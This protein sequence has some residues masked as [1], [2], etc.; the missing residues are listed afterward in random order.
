[1]RPGAKENVSFCRQLFQTHCSGGRQ[2]AALLS[3]LQSP[4]ALGAGLLRLSSAR[5]VEKDADFERKQLWVWNHLLLQRPDFSQLKYLRRPC[6]YHSALWPLCLNCH[7]RSEDARRKTSRLKSQKWRPVPIRACH[8]SQMLP[9]STSFRQRPDASRSG[10]AR[11]LGKSGT[12]HE[13]LLFAPCF[14]NSS[15]I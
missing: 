15:S 10:S 9:A 13:C 4:S 14:R 3:R 2:R 7:V 1:M 5:C 8:H 11:L 12:K 6:Q